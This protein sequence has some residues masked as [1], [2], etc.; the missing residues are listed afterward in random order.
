[1]SLDEG[2]DVWAGLPRLSRRSLDLERRAGAWAT[3]LPLRAAFRWLAGSGLDP[4]FDRPEVDWRASALTR[5]GLVAQFRWPRIGARLALG[6]EV[7]LVHAVVD[8]L[9]GFDRPTADARLQTTPVEW[10]VWTYLITRVLGEIGEAGASPF[11]FGGRPEDEAFDLSIDRVGPSPFDVEGLGD[12]VTLRWA[13]RVGPAAG[14]VR[15]WLPASLA[16]RWVEPPAGPEARPRIPPAAVEA[17]SLWR[18]VAGTSP[19]PL[20]LRRLRIG[21]VLPLVGSQLSGTPTEL[22]GGLSLTCPAGDVE[23]RLAVEPRSGAPGDRVVVAG[24]LVRSPVTTK[25]P[26]MST[27]PIRTEGPVVDPLD[28]P[29]TLTVELGRVTIPLSRLAAL[30][31][32]DVLELHRHS[33]EPVEVTSGGRTVARGDLVL[34]GDE[35]GVRVTSV[36]L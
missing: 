28:A 2:A 27:E 35:L 7:Q 18:A 12:V 36:F 11:R 14:A 24:P 3:S 10:G 23:Y 1:M 34:I 26:S 15:L 21:A 16:S 17:T 31:A 19:M 29:V 8:R 5:P 6:V 30:T 33:R 20:G 13:V 22:A 32:G 9:L 4:T 25:D